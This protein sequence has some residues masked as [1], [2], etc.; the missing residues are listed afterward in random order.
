MTKG[1]PIYVVRT[2]PN[3]DGCGHQHASPRK[4]HNCAVSIMMNRPQLT[5]ANV[6]S[7]RRHAVSLE[8]K[9]TVMETITREM[10]IQQEQET[11]A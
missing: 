2:P 8:P 3:Q 11:T 5:H 4:A 9:Y 7:V 1:Y 10:L 6:V